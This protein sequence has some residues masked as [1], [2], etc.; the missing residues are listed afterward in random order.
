MTGPARDGGVWVM[1]DKCP[2]CIFRPGNLMRLEPGRVSQMKRGADR[3]DTCIICHD[4]MDTPRAAV[5]RGYFDGHDSAL[6]Q[7]AERLGYI[8]DQS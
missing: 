6:L 4:T 7:I 1:K 2:T 8:R 5:C 3:Y